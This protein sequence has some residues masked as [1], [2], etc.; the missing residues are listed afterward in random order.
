M[1]EGEHL[2]SRLKLGDL[3]AVAFGAA[4]DVPG[5]VASRSAS[6]ETSSSPFTTCFTRS[7]TSS[8]ERS[9]LASASPSA[10]RIA[11]TSSATRLRSGA[12]PS[13]ELGWP[14][15]ATTH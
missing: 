5:Y 1:D 8:S 4:Q 6:T 7:K 3:A 9:P 15:P 13:V 14:A 10:T 12:Q 2:Q 11:K